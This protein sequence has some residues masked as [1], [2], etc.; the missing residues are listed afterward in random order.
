MRLN[1]T[2]TNK[3]FFDSPLQDPWMS[4]DAIDKVC[5]KF[6]GCDE[7]IHFF[8]S[9]LTM[10]KKK[11]KLVRHTAE[12]LADTP[13]ANIHT[14]S[15]YTFQSGKPFVH[16]ESLVGAHLA[17][18]II[19]PTTLLRDEDPPPARNS[20]QIYEAGSFLD[21]MLIPDESDVETETSKR[22]CTAGVSFFHHSQH[23]AYR[24]PTRITPLQH[25]RRN[26]P[27]FWTK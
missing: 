14:A 4:V 12:E 27:H 5:L 26:A 13:S 7:F 6:I 15:V 21:Y 25:G 16:T 3:R 11:Q 19:P 23:F 10:G 22:K 18:T 2:D 9:V 1:S 17:P 8:L 20:W 24:V